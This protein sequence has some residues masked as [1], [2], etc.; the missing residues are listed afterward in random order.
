VRAPLH[1][2]MPQQQHAVSH[3]TATGGLGLSGAVAAWLRRHHVLQASFSDHLHCELSLTLEVADWDSRAEQAGL[4]RA[5]TPA[6][7]TAASKGAPSSPSKAAAAAVAAAMGSSNA[8][9]ASSLE[10][11]MHGSGSAATHGEA[12]ASAGMQAAEAG[13]S[14]SGSSTLASAP[15]PPPVGTLDVVVKSFET[16][17]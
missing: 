13:S 1:Q 6:A 2:L 15:P 14:G 4:P 10:A 9:L 7:A 11:G 5:L 8:W 17:K 12:A 3:L 16:R